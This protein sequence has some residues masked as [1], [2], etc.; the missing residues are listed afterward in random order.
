[1]KSQG[2][3]KWILSGNPEMICFYYAPNSVK[4]GCIFNLNKKISVRYV[5]MRTPYMKFIDRQALGLGLSVNKFYI[6]TPQQNISEWYSLVSI[7]CLYHL[8]LWLYA[9]PYKGSE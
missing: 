1:M 5:L 2:I 9:A 6:W 8:P 3:S 4:S 7:T